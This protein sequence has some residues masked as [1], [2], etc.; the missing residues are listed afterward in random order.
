MRDAKPLEQSIRREFPLLFGGDD[1][2]PSAQFFEAYNA[3]AD[4]S[5]RTAEPAFKPE[6]H[7]LQWTL[8]TSS[9]GLLALI[10]FKIGSIRIGDASVSVNR[11]VL[12]WYGGFLLA[13]MLSFILRALLDFSRAELARRKDAD[14]LTQLGCLVDAAYLKRRI[15]HYFWIGLFNQMGERYDAYGKIA[16]SQP[17]LDLPHTEI[18]NYELDIEALKEIE[19]YSAQIESHDAFVKALIASLD[20][21]LGRFEN[22]LG[23]F[24]ER[25]RRARQNDDPY[26]LEMLELK[27]F[28]NSRAL[29]DQYLKP[30]FDVRGKLA[31]DMLD[32]VLDVRATREWR[33]LEAQLGL[34]RKARGIRR[35]YAF[36]EIALPLGLAI[37]ALAYDVR[38]L[39][40]H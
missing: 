15:Q 14:K 23:E 28:P 7:K 20:A 35:L 19:E 21:D 30:W 36:T 12:T 25:I 29:F 27:R 32:T 1:L 18:P 17:I 24:D 8:L 33:M 26:A 11:D 37:A 6:T 38:T 22:R 5:I 34:Q 31:S 2:V 13:L 9:L 40:I 16:Q 4:Y 39:L 3:V 10:L